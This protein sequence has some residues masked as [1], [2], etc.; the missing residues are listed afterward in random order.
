MTD[1]QK[2]TKEE[3]VLKIT[4]LEQ[5]NKRL[6]QTFQEAER[7]EF[8]WTGNLGQWFWDFTTNEVTFNPLK[9]EAIGYMQEDLPEKVPYQFFTDK[10]HPDDK[11]E[12]MRLMSEHL[13]GEIP[14]WEVKYRIQA[15]DGTWK[16]Y[17][18]RGKVTERNEKG[19]PL[20]L[21]GIVFDITQEEQERKQLQ[22]KNE[23]L[24]NQRKKDTLTSLYSRSA[25]TVELVKYTNRARKQNQPL[26]LVFLS[27]D[28]YS[29]Y[30]KNFGIVGTEEVLTVTG[31]I[32][33]SA[34]QK[35]TVAGRYRESAFLI[36]LENTKKED[37]Y[38]WAETIRQAV[39]ET[40]FDLPKQVS[41]SGGISV[42]DSEET[43]SELVQKAA[44]KLTAAQ[45]NGGN[46]IIV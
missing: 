26:S 24:T 46:Q 28:H 11:E 4:S 15:K 19:E 2:Y 27:I 13:R 14:V 39:L 36:L 42:Y 12:V 34:M 40:L 21:T 43:I 41:I 10:V 31:Q 38:R 8:G 37:A 23:L 20:F 29:D 25:I 32:I 3:L 1:Y 6:L 30:E 17:Q 45:K 35:Q 33:Q 7:L 9:A 44:L 22:T 5:L 16:V 18:D